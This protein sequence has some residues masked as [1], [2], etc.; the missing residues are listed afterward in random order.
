[1]TATVIRLPSRE[2]VELMPEAIPAASSGADLSA[3]DV[4]GATSIE[5]PQ[6]NRSREGSPAD[7][8]SL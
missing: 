4:M 1:M 2:T 5:S 6:A 8:K 3:V 7:Q